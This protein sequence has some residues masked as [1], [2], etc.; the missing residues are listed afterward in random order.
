MHGIKEKL[1]SDRPKKEKKIRKIILTTTVLFLMPI[2]AGE[3]QIRTETE[4]YLV[5]DFQSH[6]RVVP[7]YEN[8]VLTTIL[9]GNSSIEKIGNLYIPFF[10]LRLALPQPLKP[11]ADIISIEYQSLDTI[12]LPPSFS[13]T[14]DTLKT[15]YFTDPGYMANL[16]VCL[17]KIPGVRIKDGKLEAIRTARIKIIYRIAQESRAN[18][19]VRA[20]TSEQEENFYRKVILNNKYINQWVHKK[21]YPLKKA[22]SYPSGKWIKIP[23]TNDGIYYITYSD[24]ERKGIIE[25]PVEINRIF[26]FSNSTGGAEL[27]SQ[28]LQEIPENLKENAIL[29][30]GEDELYGSGDSIIFYGKGT[31]K[32]LV[33]ENK[34]LEYQKNCYSDTN[35][36][37]LCISN[38]S[39]TPKRLQIV[40]YSESADTTISTG[41]FLIHHENDFFNFIKSGK[42]WYGEKFSG[43]GSSHYFRFDLP[44]ADPAF[45]GWVRI[46]TIG[47]TYSKG[48][49]RHVFKLFVNDFPSP[50][51]TWTS[52]NYFSSYTNT[53]LDNQLLNDGA[54]LFQITYTSNL[55]QAEAYLDYIE[56]F[57]KS[58]VKIEKG[59]NKF[60]IFKCGKK[61]K[62][63]SE[64]DISNPL[65]FD[66]T[67]W[68]NVKLLL[69][70]IENGKLTFTFNSDTTRHF[71]ILSRNDFKSPDTLLFIEDNRWDKLRKPNISGAE[72]III[73]RKEFLE[74]AETIAEVH[75]KFVDEKDRLKTMIV[76][77]DD[78]LHE[79]NADI[80]D[81]HAIR[82]FLQYAFQYWSPSPRFVLLLGD[83]TY[84]YRAIES[85]EG[86]LILTYQ[87]EP[88]KIYSSADNSYATDARFTYVNGNDYYMDLA[89]G[90]ITARTPEEAL[91]AAEK[92]KKYLTSPEY[93]LWRNRIT[94]VA[95]DVA[96]PHNF[97]PYHIEDTEENVAVK[98]PL[99]MDIKKI[100]LEEFPAVY[101][102][103]TYGVKKPDA[104]AAILDQL[105]KGTSIINYMGHGS[106]TVWAQEYVLEMARDINRINTGM[107]LPFWLSAT[108]SWGHFDDISNPCMAEQLVLLKENGAI[109][110]LSATRGVYGSANAAF[111]N[112]FYSK[113]FNKYT[114]NRLR[115]GEILLTLID[116]YNS[117]DEKYVLFGD[118]ALY[119]ALPYEKAEFDRPQNDTLKVLSRAKFT[120]RI[121]AGNNVELKGTGYV[122]NYDSD[123]HVTRTVYDMQNQPHT[124]S[125]TLPGEKLFQGKINFQS[126]F[127]TSFFIPKDISWSVNPGKVTFFGWDSIN[128]LEIAGYY[129]S[130]IYYGIENV[131]DTVGPKI[132]IQFEG[133]NFVNGDE[134]PTD[135]D[136]II[137]VSDEH[138]IN[139]SGQLGHTITLTFD[140][141][142]SKSFNVTELFIYDSDSDTSG[143][144]VTPLP[145]GL[146]TGYHTLTVKA[147]DNA[148]NPSR[149][150]ISF[151]LTPSEKM[152]ILR[153]Y[154]VPNPFKDKTNFTFYLTK[155]CQILIKIYTIRGL[156]IK[157]IDEGIIYSAGYNIVEW[158]GKDDFGNDIARGIYVYKII[159]TDLNGNET[160]VIGKMIKGF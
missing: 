157:T 102:E 106:P 2:Y 124:L 33:E 8:G 43:T 137:K 87:V 30:T 155:D 50:I 47:G 132:E 6:D 129:D 150:T 113:L 156:R 23:V 66:V 99:S 54:N 35:F 158:D 122:I 40:P 25:G 116:G 97:E 1:K 148:N 41:Y 9:L 65:I 19:S 73:T 136:L 140:N 36:Y 147:W 70:R 112:Q 131:M 153:A 71:Y 46:R 96:R 83:G 4:S 38:A 143:T 111:V 117:N 109:A 105:E 68:S 77:Q 67:D 104:T 64:T 28:P 51:A 59:E 16:P 20:R 58:S 32:I 98:I 146:K 86:N 78:I 49:A 88:Y 95:D 31:Y 75:S 103:S 69:P 139:I 115:I 160:S 18:Q 13:K 7:I 15:L 72:Y 80:L 125:Y 29:I 27:P 92:I 84:D 108:C 149:E 52:T 55:S 22:S 123:R 26:L 89:I 154:N 130:L 3:F 85:S 60:W 151:Y 94:L 21:A 145:R 5:I 91:N 110:T 62:I 44:G 81:P 90:R 57:Y 48:G 24:L 34:S 63:S 11:R 61:V 138:G 128:H 141:D 121:P 152:K 56:L 76:F 53:R 127:K 144:V 42:R 126:T 10:K 114:A 159:A 133:L 101:D 17:L 135:K 118:P 45:T 12:S 37:W 120:G 14:L 74:A 39:G 107:K 93:G 100:Y 79:F 82:Y 142:G 134:V 119:L